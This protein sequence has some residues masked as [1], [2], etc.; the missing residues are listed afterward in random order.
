MIEC[1][2]DGCSNPAG[3]NVPG[4]KDLT[5]RSCGHLMSKFGITTPERDLLLHNQDNKCKLCDNPIQFSSK[6]KGS[7]RNT[8][9]VDHA[10]KPFKIRGILCGGCNTALGILGDTP[11]MIRRAL[12][13]VER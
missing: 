4:R 8:A 7:S 6:P 9:V 2:I 12:K 13:Y 5:C 3:K 10:E 1:R 11:E